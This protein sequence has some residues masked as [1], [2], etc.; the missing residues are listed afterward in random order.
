MHEDIKK[1][2][3]TMLLY[4]QFCVEEFGLI[5][6]TVIHVLG[7]CGHILCQSCRLKLVTNIC[8]FCKTDI[9]PCLE[10]PI[11]Y[12][13]TPCHL[14]NVS[15]NDLY[16]CSGIEMDTIYTDMTYGDHPI[17]VLLYC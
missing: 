14:L 13:C 9:K 12:K 1:R 10:F 5:N 17:H 6:N 8:P 4:C 15:R 3:P 11:Q 7:T 16:K 2:K